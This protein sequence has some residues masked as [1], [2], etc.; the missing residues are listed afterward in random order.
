M[1]NVIAD[2]VEPAFLRGGGTMA[3]LI[4]RFDWS[5]T[6]LGPI[7]GWPRSLTT[8]VGTILR[9]PV[10]IVTLWGA[11]GV[12]IYNDAYSVFAGGRHPGILGSKVREGWDEV[13]DFNDNVMRTVLEAGETLSYE[14]QELTL[15]RNG[16]PEPVWMNLDYS[17]VL[18]EDG[19]RIG[20][21]AIVVETT[22]K[23]QAERWLRGET[24]RLQMMV[25]QAPG[26]SA[27]LQGPEHVFVMANPAYRRLVGNREIIGKSLREAVPEVETQGFTSLL[28][29][30][31][32]SGKPY[33]GHALPVSLD[34]AAG[35][36]DLRYLDFVYQPVRD[37]RGDVTGVFVQGTDVT[38]RV[39]AAKALEESEARFRLVAE[40]APVMLWM[41]DPNGNCVYLNKAQRTFWGVPTEDLSGFTWA[42]TLHPDDLEK[43][44]IPY[45]EAMQKQT[46][47]TVEARYRRADGA[48]RTLAT[49]GRPRFSAEGRFLGMIGVNV[50]VTEQRAAELA[51][52]KERQRLEVLNSSGARIAA[53]LDLERIVQTVTDAGVALTGAQFGAFFYNVISDAGESYMLYALS[54]VDR[55]HFAQFPMPRNSPLFRPTF[56]GKAVVRA[57]DVLQHPNYGKKAP[58]YGMPKGHLPVR[59]YL[60]MPV[61]SRTGEVIGGLFFGHAE[62]SRFK[63]EHEALL[64]GLAGQ[65]AV[66]IDNA[67]LFRAVERENRERARAEEQLRA[68]NETLEARVA[69][70]IEV[71]H[72]AEAALQQAQKMEAIGQLTGGVAHD[73]NNLLMAVT[74]SLE[75]LRKRLPHDPQLTR[76][77]DNAMEGAKRG[78]ALTSRMLTFARRQELKVTAVD[79]KA[80]FAGMAELL[81]RSLGPMISIETDFAPHLP[82][83]RTDP[84]QLETALINIAVNARDAMHEQGTIRIAASET[85]V[86]G[87]PELAPGRYV[88]LSVSDTGDG[89]DEETLRRAGEPFF[90]TKDV[91]KGT[92]LGLSMV[93]GLAHQSGGRL[94][95]KS[96]AGEGT[97]AEIWLPVAESAPGTAAASPAADRSVGQPVRSLC[98]LAVDDDALVRMNTVAMLEDLGHTVI[99]ASSAIDALAK[100]ALT[101]VDLVITDHA[102]PQMS[103]AQLATALRRDHP[104]LPIVLAT[105]YAEL[106]DGEDPGLPR[107]AKPFSERQLA[108]ILESV[109]TRPPTASD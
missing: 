54:G 4:A 99:E 20:V 37:R 83:V 109:V 6:A 29:Q 65:A 18:D 75:L 76:L 67:R 86:A 108:H 105:G 103:G 30:V 32:S 96:Q 42:G 46:G 7:S 57:D 33:T 60:A 11:D 17:P 93:H 24:D 61:V 45:N 3:D 97:T 40:T 8:V 74:G 79:V 106:P 51:W 16:L 5:T 19:R 43:L 1:L 28:D 15:Y 68:L 87:D 48:W 77:L 49:D 34:N 71:R 58:H 90:T 62:P 53:E 95:L 91:G 64:S 94:V 66:A 35:A 27:L 92:G 104:H 85:S 70:E 88:R 38:D 47:F 59:S 80:L 73:F 107:L 52:Q 25:E 63:E 36:L 39:L 98:V 72:K 13:A 89:M 23:V 44:A 26:F 78:T 82:L 100:V 12:M 14:D 102:M 101:P 31:Y 56:E 55:S 10:P 9:S 69:E 81:Q 22:K 84:T 41:G 2:P 21:M 50:D